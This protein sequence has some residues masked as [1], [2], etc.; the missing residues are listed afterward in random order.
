MS[1][2]IPLSKGKVAL[3]SDEDYEWLSAYS[4]HVS[5]GYAVRTYRDQS[6]RDHKIRMHRE[7][8]ER[9]GYDLTGVAQVDHRNLDKLDNKR[10]NLRPCSPSQNQANRLKLSTNT[11]GYRGVSWHIKKRKWM[12]S[13]YHNGKT[14]FL[15][16]FD[17]PVDAAIAYNDRAKEVFGEYCRLNE[18]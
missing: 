9:M 11:S 5:G 7:I 18:V 2:A 8:M 15:G 1:K 12:A 13:L 6:G 4:W 16:Y 3:V 10:E 14:E 17:D